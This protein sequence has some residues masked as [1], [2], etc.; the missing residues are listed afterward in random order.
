MQTSEKGIAFIKQNEGFVDHVYD[1][2][3][4]PAIG[5]GHDLLPG[6][7]FPNGLDESGGDSLLR[8]ED[9]LKLESKVN[10]LIP[11]DVTPT[12]NQFDALMDFAYNLGPGNLA[13]MLHHGWAQIPT[14]IPA[15]CYKH[16]NGV[17]VKDK[18]LAARRAKEVVLFLS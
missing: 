11:Q 12:Q 18:G 16:V 9:L 13:T 15:W 10:A 14:Q 6:E 7:S 17:A 8:K 2:N 3:G 1:D 4:K 5:Y